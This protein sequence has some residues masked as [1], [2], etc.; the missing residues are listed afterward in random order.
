MAFAVGSGLS[1]AS[2]DADRIEA[3]IDSRR[4]ARLRARPLLD[5]EVSD[6]DVEAA[7]CGGMMGAVLSGSCFVED[8]YKGPMLIFCGD[9]GGEPI[10]ECPFCGKRARRVE[11][12]KK[13]RPSQPRSDP[14]CGK[15]RRFQGISGGTGH[16][17]PYDPGDVP[18][19][20]PAGKSIRTHL[21]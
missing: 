21:I 11:R 20:F 5:L 6:V 18:R 9:S 7:C 17:T 15:L 13:Y 14:Q 16:P 2:E 10:T 3:E 4:E 12:G 8:T 1:G 19:L